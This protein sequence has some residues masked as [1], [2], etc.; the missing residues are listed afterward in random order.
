MIYNQGWSDYTTT[1]VYRMTGA[2]RAAKYGAV[3][4][5]VRSVASDSIYSV[6]AGI[7]ES[8]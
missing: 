2:A 5:L 8:R 3:A 6:H 4:M 1:V 7:Q